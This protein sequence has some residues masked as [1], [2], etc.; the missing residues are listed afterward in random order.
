MGTVIVTNN[1]ALIEALDQL[2][3]PMLNYT[4]AGYDDFWCVAIN[5]YTCAGCNQL[6][7]HAQV[8]DHF[9]VIWEEKDD[10]TILEVASGLKRAEMNPRIVN[11]NRNDGPCVEFYEAIRRGWVDEFP[12]GY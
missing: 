4:D 9:I 7:S 10:D 8:G 3:D 2:V 12:H 11:Y 1:P 6:I 5:P